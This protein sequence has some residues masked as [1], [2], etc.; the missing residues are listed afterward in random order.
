MAY[1]VDACICARAARIQSV[2]NMC[3]LCIIVGVSLTIMT[4]RYVRLLIQLVSQL[5]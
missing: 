3:L 4:D 2:S 1:K 5:W